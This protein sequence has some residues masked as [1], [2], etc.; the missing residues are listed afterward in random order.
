[1][2]WEGN[3]CEKCGPEARLRP[4]HDDVEKHT[5]PFSALSRARGT[6][7]SNQATLVPEK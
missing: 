1:M 2:S 6:L 7:S 3:D 5:C 4:D